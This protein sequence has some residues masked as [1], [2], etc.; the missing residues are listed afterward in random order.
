MLLRVDL[1]VV[2]LV[3]VRAAEVAHHVVHHICTF[4]AGPVQWI[5]PTEHRRHLSPLAAGI[6]S[7]PR[8]VDEAALR[9]RYTGTTC[10]IMYT[11]FED[12][13]CSLSPR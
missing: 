10:R 13:C 11:L 9:G 2:P 1:L 7:V 4:L 5:H 8:A 12:P 3:L 6:G